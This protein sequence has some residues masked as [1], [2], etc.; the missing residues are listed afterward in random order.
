M[1]KPCSDIIVNSMELGIAGFRRVAK[2]VNE[3]VNDKQQES[4]EHRNFQ[5]ILSTISSMS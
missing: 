4:V 2:R 5:C 3:A 1:V